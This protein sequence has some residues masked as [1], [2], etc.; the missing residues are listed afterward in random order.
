[1]SDGQKKCTVDEQQCDAE[2]QARPDRACATETKTE[3]VYERA[4]KA[5]HEACSRGRLEMTIPVD[6]QRDHDCLIAAG[7]I[8]GEA[9][10][11]RIASVEGR[12]GMRLECIETTLVAHRNT[13]QQDYDRAVAAV[14]RAE[15]AERERDEYAKALD[16]ICALIDGKLTDLT[17]GG[18]HN[19]V[20]FA[21]D[22]WRQEIERERDEA[23]ARAS[24]LE[25]ALKEWILAQ[26]AERSAANEWARVRVR[27]WRKW[28]P[29][30]KRMPKDAVTMDSLPQ[31]EQDRI[32]ERWDRDM[33]P[34]KE[35]EA[36]HAQARIRLDAA[37]GTARAALGIDPPK[38]G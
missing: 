8:A 15:S 30:P 29:L 13:A 37:A 17:G 26:D 12:C 34:I 20:V 16:D 2:C 35:A 3:N 24:A 36:T 38:E 14:K 21:V 23:R 4:R 7:L 6:E 1:M 32:R 28:P 10:E 5:L 9:A 19:G 25:E 18:G 31:E 27:E 11:K 22:E 33:A